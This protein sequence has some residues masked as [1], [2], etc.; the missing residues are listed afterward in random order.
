MVYDQL[1]TLQDIMDLMTKIGENGQPRQ[2]CDEEI[3]SQVR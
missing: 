3:L 1:L 2:G